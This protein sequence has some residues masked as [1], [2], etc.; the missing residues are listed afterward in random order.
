[1]N[2]IL[3]LYNRNPF[4]PRFRGFIGLDRPGKRGCYLVC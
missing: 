3:K 1:L 4:K 2:Y